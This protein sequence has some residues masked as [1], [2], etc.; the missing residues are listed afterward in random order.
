MRLC[1]HG[2]RD[3]VSLGSLQTFLGSAGGLSSML[4]Y[5]K[6]RSSPEEDRVLRQRDPERERT[7]TAAGPREVSVVGWE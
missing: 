6:C 4:N 3:L 5:I 2:G 1:K 7:Q